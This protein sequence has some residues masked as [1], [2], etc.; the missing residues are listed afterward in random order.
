MLTFGVQ[1]LLVG[2]LQDLIFGG[3]LKRLIVQEQDE[4]GIFT[5]VG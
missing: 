2:V 1:F 3:L 5:S 4:T